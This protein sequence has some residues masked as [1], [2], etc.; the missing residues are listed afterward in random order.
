MQSFFN[1]IRINSNVMVVI[2]VYDTDDMYVHVY[3]VDFTN[4]IFHCNLK[5][6]AESKRIPQFKTPRLEPLRAH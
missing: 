2:E 5:T 3:D 6:S 1:F 4:K